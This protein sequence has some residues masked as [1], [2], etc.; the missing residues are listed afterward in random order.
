MSW[1]VMQGMKVTYWAD[2]TCNDAVEGQRLGDALGHAAVTGL[3][4][5][6]D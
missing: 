4:R 1:H 3:N 6:M 2:A 5:F